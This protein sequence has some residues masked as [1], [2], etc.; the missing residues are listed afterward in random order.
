[1]QFS[2]R[3]PWKELSQILLQDGQLL[4]NFGESYGSHGKA[5]FK[6][7]G[8]K[9]SDLKDFIIAVHSNSPTTSIE[10]DLL[11]PKLLGMNHLE[12]SGSRGDLTF[13]SLWEKDLANRFASTA[14]IPLE[15][16]AELQNGDYKII[17]QM[18]FGGLSAV[19]LCRHKNQETVVLKEAVVPINS[20]AASREKALEMFKRETHILKGIFHPH[21]ARVKDHFV[22]RSHDYL[23]LEHIDGVDLRAYVSEHGPQAER[24]I[25]RWA[26]EIADILQYLHEHSPPIIHRDVTPD[27]LVIDRTGALKLIDFGAANEFV[28]AATGTLIGKQAYIA[29]EQFRGKALP[30]SDIY[31]LGC[32]L[33]YL[34]TGED[35]EPL[36]ESS[37]PPAYA[38]SMP[39]LNTLIQS[40][41]QIEVSD[42]LLSMEAVKNCIQQRSET[43][44]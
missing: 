21:I 19:Y 23:V 25:I 38:S 13:T 30:Q 42:R 11:E 9:S 39:A 16:G 24:M 22:E 3:R 7:D 4:L 43:A 29:P 28:G 33:Y 34:A 26:A 14:F 35:P 10:L 36:S 15:V 20:D 44:Q 1:M 32:T 27:N 37:L 12:A 17:G 6:L 5:M 2:I 31:S 41:T 8:F 40:C 18:S